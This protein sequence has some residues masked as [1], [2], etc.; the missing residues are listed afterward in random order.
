MIADVPANPPAIMIVGDYVNPNPIF[1]EPRNRS[2]RA[3][4]VPTAD[5]SV[6]IVPVPQD[7]G[8]DSWWRHYRHRDGVVTRLLDNLL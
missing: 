2:S 1:V 6:V 4:V 5:G 8:Y 3:T 7:Y